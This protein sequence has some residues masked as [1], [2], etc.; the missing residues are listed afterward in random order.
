MAEDIEFRV[1]AQLE[2][3]LSGALSGMSRQTQ[4]AISAI[5]KNL[6]QAALSTQ[7]LRRDT[8]ELN[9]VFAKGYRNVVTVSGAVAKLSSNYITLRKTIFEAKDAQKLLGKALDETKSKRIS[10]EQ[11]VKREQRAGSKANA[12]IL[13]E[14]KKNIQVLKEQEKQIRQVKSAF[15]SISGNS[16]RLM[17]SALVKDIGL[18]GE[19]MINF[20]KNLNY[21][22]RNLTFALTLPIVGFVRYGI[23]NLRKLDK[24]VVRTRKILDD[25]F[26]SPEDLD[27]FM[28]TLGDQLDNLSFKVTDSYK[29]LGIARELV[30]GL[31]ADF[32]Q[33]GV[34]PEQI[35]NLVRLTAELEKIGDVDIGVAREFV[36]SAFQQAVRIQNT[37]ITAAGG[38]V[39]AAEVA[40]RAVN[41]ITGSLYQL[42]VIENKT[43]LALK[44]I[45]DA[46]PE[47]QGVAT[48]FGLT[49]LEAA[50][51]FAPMIA[52]GF[53]VGASAN[54]I[55]VSLQRI[56]A[57]TKQNKAIME[58][59]GKA[60]GEDFKFQ[61]GIG[62]ETIQ[63]L[64]DG[65]TALEKSSYGTQG[66]LEFFAR[67][68]GVRQGPR[69]EQAIRQLS[70]FQNQLNNAQSETSVVFGAIARNINNE[71][72]KIGI[73]QRFTADSI[74][75]IGEITR[76]S[77]KAQT[78]NNQI[79][80]DAIVKGQA[81][82][83]A[84]LEELY[85]DFYKNITNEAGKVLLAQ[86]LGPEQAKLIYEK[87]LAAANN[88][89]EAK[90]GRA[91][92][93]FKAFSRQLVPIFVDIVEAILPT[94]QRFTN[95][96][97]SLPESS[98]K[99]FGLGLA[100]VALAGPLTTVTAIL[101]Q[102]GGIVLKIFSSL[103][104][105]LFKF[106][107]IPKNISNGL[108]EMS[109]G[110]AGVT[111]RMGL[112]GKTMD[113]ISNRA[114]RLGRSF[115]I[116][117]GNMGKYQR[118]I[119]VLGERAYAM[120]GTSRL[121][122]S[123]LL[124][125]SSRL[126]QNT[127]SDIDVLTRQ[128]INEATESAGRGR[129][130][131]AK[132]R[133]LQNL[134]GMSGGVDLFPKNIKNV[135]SSIQNLTASEKYLAA[136]ADIASG[137]LGAQSK[138]ST[139]K[140]QVTDD[141]TYKIKNI[142]K[143]EEELQEAIVD[144]TNATNAATAASPAKTSR[145]RAKNRLLDQFG[146]DP[147]TGTFGPTSKTMLALPP[148]GGTSKAIGDI[149]TE[150]VETPLQQLIAYR[151]QELARLA[152]LKRR[153]PASAEKAMQNIF[154]KA[155]ELGLGPEIAGVTEVI[156]NFEDDVV[157]ILT[158]PKEAIAKAT[159]KR[160]SLTPEAIMGAYRRRNDGVVGGVSEAVDL[161]QREVADVLGTTAREF[162]E[163]TYNNIL[164][165]ISE[166]KILDP[167]PIVE[168]MEN[169]KKVQSSVWSRFFGRAERGKEAPLGRFKLFDSELKG[170]TQGAVQSALDQRFMG[171]KTGRMRSLMSSTRDSAERTVL[172]SV[173]DLVGVLDEGTAEQFEKAV[174]ELAE[175]YPK[176]R[177]Q[178]LERG[179]QVMGR[180]TG[181]GYRSRLIPGRQRAIG[182]FVKEISDLEKEIQ[183]KGETAARTIKLRQA[184]QQLALLKKSSFFPTDLPIPKSVDDLND[185]FRALDSIPFSE[186]LDDPLSKGI[187]TDGPESSSRRLSSDFKRRI[188]RA[189]AGRF[190]GKNIISGVDP[191]ESWVKQLIDRRE[192]AQGATRARLLGRKFPGI[193]AAA[194]TLSK[195]Y[196][197]MS[198]LPL[199]A[200]GPALAGMADV[201]GG[202]LGKLFGGGAAGAAMMA[203]GGKIDKDAFGEKQLIDALLTRRGFKGDAAKQFKAKIVQQLSGLG[204]R[205]QQYLE[206][207]TTPLTKLS[208]D[209]IRTIDALPAIG[210]EKLSS[211][212]IKSVLG[213]VREA[214]EKVKKSTKSIVNWSANTLDKI[215]LAGDDLESRVDAIPGM[216]DKSLKQAAASNEAN[217]KNAAKRSAEGGK[218]RVKKIVEDPL[219][220]VLK[221]KDKMLKELAGMSRLSD[222]SIEA[223]YA[224]LMNAAKEQ[225]SF[226]Q[227]NAVLADFVDEV[228]K[229]KIAAG[230]ASAD[231]ATD[232]A[233]SVKDAVVVTSQTSENEWDVW[234]KEAAEEVKE[235]S[236]QAS[237]AAG[238]K[239]KK[240]VCDATDKVKEA[241]V[242]STKVPTPQVDAVATAAAAEAVADTKESAVLAA[243][244]A[245][246][247]TKDY[248]DDAVNTYTLTYMGLLKGSL[249]SRIAARAGAMMQGIYNAP[250]AAL[251]YGSTKAIS[252]ASKPLT[253]LS[254]SAGMASIALGKMGSVFLGWIPIFGKSISRGLVNRGS[255]AISTTNFAR[256]LLTSKLLP[257]DKALSRSS[258][259]FRK[260][261]V[262]VGAAAA[263]IGQLINPLKIIGGLIQGIMKAIKIGLALTGI[264]AVIMLLAAAVVAVK[265]SIKNFQPIVEKLKEAW[266]YISESLTIIAKPLMDMVLAFSG[267]SVSAAKTGDALEDS[268]NSSRS[269]F[270]AIVTFIVWVSK[271][272]RENAERIAK[273]VKEKVVPVLVQIINTVIAIGKVIYYIFTGNFDK[274][275]D[276][277]AEMFMRIG[278]SFLNLVKTV[279]PVLQELLKITVLAFAKLADFILKVLIQAAKAAFEWIEKNAMDTIW[280]IVAGLRGMAPVKQIS[281]EVLVDQYGVD[282][283]NEI[284]TNMGKEIPAAAS[285]AG[286]EF[287]DEFI[288]GAFEQFENRSDV[289]Q[290]L[291][292]WLRDKI[293]FDQGWIGGIVDVLYNGADALFGALT[294]VVD[295]ALNSIA[296]SFKKKF[297]RDISLPV[298]PNVSS[299][300]AKKF[301]K[302]IDDLVAEV[303]T[304]LEQSGEAIGDG[305]AGAIED[306]VEKAI[307][308]L[309]QRF[310]DLVVD[311]LGDQVSKYKSQLTELLE[312]QKEKQ[313]QYFDDQLAALDA[314]EKAEEELTETKEYETG[315]R[316]MIEDR[317]L[318]RAKYQRERALAIYEGRVDD[319]RTLDL[320]EEKNTKSFRD[321]LDQYDG[322]RA[323]QLQSR[324][325]ETV[326]QIL[327]QQKK[328]AEKAFDEIIKN[329]EKFVEDIGKY[330]TY[331]QEELAKQFEEI[332]G[333]AAE[334]TAAMQT[335]FREYYLEIPKIIQQYTDPTV[336][337]FSEPLDQ[338]I[339]I[340]KTKFGLGA[341]SGASADSILGNTAALMREI[342][343]TF[344]DMGPTAGQSFERAFSAVIDNY[345]TPI[346]DKMQEAFFGFDIAA[347]F[348]EAI[349]NANMVLI[350][351]QQ[352]LIDGMGSLVKDMIH[353]LDPAIAKWY[354]LQAAIEAAAN[355][356]KNSSGS[357]NN[358][359]SYYPPG[360]SNVSTPVTGDI[361]SLIKSKFD[362]WFP[363]SFFDAGSEG[364][365]ARANVYSKILSTLPSI[366]SDIKMGRYTM[367]AALQYLA[368]NT[369]IN[370]YLRKYLNSLQ[371]LQGVGIEGTGS[372]RYFGGPIPRFGYGGRMKKYG[373]GGFAVPGF[374]ST[375]VP[376]LLHGGEY[377]INAKAVQAIGMSTLQNLNNM[378]FTSPGRMQSPQVT[379]INETK[380]VNIYVDNFIGEQQWFESMMKEYN[381]KVAPRNQK[382]AGLEVRTV[383]SYSGLNRGL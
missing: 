364:T 220:K 84:E 288:D 142:T 92:E 304:A 329:Y 263:G 310:V 258:T 359:S 39:N 98:K 200:L 144:T 228:E 188:E 183:E 307:K 86:A 209:V 341:D 313:L 257:D 280:R 295:N 203:V 284:W 305:A 155:R 90:L 327:E 235:D 63:Y 298:S 282:K 157:R 107:R 66:A 367:T 162:N 4:N 126:P 285:A 168:A 76:F 161:A 345:I 369:G 321:D 318:Q 93:T 43:V 271:K 380:N 358:G 362:I 354:A 128:I 105:K 165:A 14:T 302:Q 205:G 137:A 167:T 47:M 150:S 199:A 360:D 22:G 378:R 187:L 53:E 156:A 133:F 186:N 299:E 26:S 30:Q 123:S 208:D 234:A 184:R 35:F 96:V 119:A 347:I 112:F 104:P 342:G 17:T 361:S 279:I 38:V 217:I 194:Q 328:D 70:Q 81:G 82:A 61:A 106:A 15:D 180:T 375:A 312:E 273:F 296:E 381:V 134:L 382:S 110:F 201:P 289:S 170:K 37:A 55:K 173:K 145:R 324:Q 175:K 352:K 227:A 253:N 333:K 239:V 193:R 120:N 308:D 218:K 243:L 355:A 12:Q 223:R 151:D 164:D 229:I 36:T 221:Q 45:A 88:T 115:D 213:K 44:S 77:A 293:S 322:D 117:F 141:L 198:M 266:G 249:G 23:D 103:V 248:V 97:A 163:T 338:L 41:M 231:A 237:A 8:T 60:L 207:L 147:V 159:K 259:I 268:A 212:G 236:A 306:A 172:D 62:I 68:F 330:G 336:G 176:Q 272:F 6:Q 42:N 339:A 348:Q 149:V 376:A 49:M 178:I 24:E 136:W 64:V 216:V 252:L 283:A 219:T 32:A 33:L 74:Q 226:G 379:T 18:V 124:S 319:A 204:E 146:Y 196:G 317:D 211:E 67:L 269:A 297:G 377:V 58:E 179:R 10:L 246:D 135:T 139:K 244:A 113:A 78:E 351:E 357:S 370:L 116:M 300:A 99:L 101:A 366:I 19:Q 270:A 9:N 343:Q 233:E 261:V 281:Y 383:S 290:T 197:L 85:G 20:G 331:N 118:D 87:E 34:Q 344:T 325:R 222:S 332:R 152:G 371:F 192:G 311:Y 166:G 21:V 294:K 303:N 75:A 260:I 181:T 265:N 374:S 95:W 292:E 287:T 202:L 368:P 349:D 91:R 51:F 140:S 73:S 153:G 247:F 83:V 356:A 1:R 109:G 102:V 206:V 346:V 195:N 143:A 50:S 301:Q 185:I 264:G 232:T 160:K 80:Y 241:V 274:A 323:K 171:L 335:S 138:K 214:P 57:P 40:D 131:P 72:S 46:F 215:I 210:K 28:G 245:V 255:E 79:V 29:G 122:T 224:V 372:P 190:L 158:Q 56:V 148:A 114:P 154:N 2:D 230:K 89:V 129:V 240:D 363:R 3:Q 182:G 262:D 337:F 275:G 13:I 25:A 286:A 177:M 256:G 11:V 5:T 373:L 111:S 340:A 100:F 71:L 130:K 54:S 174:I 353:L 191:S 125:R 48:T 169:N 365:L 291:S 276:A 250:V 108:V 65:F 238:R 132:Q 127:R 278:Y 27:T 52:A 334:A 309:Q 59:L 320:E 314:L 189:R 254:K 326:K 225:L 350:R 277:G 69:M 267:A 16:F 31:A 316:R 7:Q 121:L 242:A 315:R 251:Q 94:L